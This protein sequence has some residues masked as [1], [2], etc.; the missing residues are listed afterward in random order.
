MKFLIAIL[1]FHFFLKEFV[2]YAVANQADLNLSDEQITNLEFRWTG[3]LTK[4]NA[5]TN[6]ITFG[7]G[8]KSDIVGAYNDDSLYVGGIQGQIKSNPSVTLNGTARLALNIPAD[9]PRRGHV[10]VSIIR[11]LVTF[12]KK[13]SM[14]IEIFV[15]D[16]GAPTRKAKPKDVYSIGTKQ[17]ITAPDAAEPKPEAYIMQ[18][19]EKKT[20][21]TKYFTSD[22]VG[23]KLWMKAF[24]ISP[25]G[26][27]GPDGD[28]FSTIIM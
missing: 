28:V 24:Y 2:A 22:Q 7:P 9:K 17:V 15:V 27:A 6:P 25:T 19:P 20:I 14:E 12:L 8:T 26:E 4:I 3:W 21:F 11:P 10:P 23:Q 13:L 5:Y 16:P 18:L 1:Q